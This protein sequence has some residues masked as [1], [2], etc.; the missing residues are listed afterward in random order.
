MPPL[1]EAID[2][3]T[4]NDEYVAQLLARDARDRSLKYSALG[5][6]AYLPRRWVIP[7]IALTISS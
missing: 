4:S 1:G 3:P 5:L 7:A 6:E 2:D